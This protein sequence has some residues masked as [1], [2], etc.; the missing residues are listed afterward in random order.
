MTSALLIQ[1]ILLQSW[2]NEALCAPYRARNSQRL[3]TPFLF[4]CPLSRKTQTEC[5]RH[6]ARSQI[7]PKRPCRKLSPVGSLDLS[8]LCKQTKFFA[9][10]CSLVGS[11]YGGGRLVVGIYRTRWR[12]RALNCN[13]SLCIRAA[14]DH[15]HPGSTYNLVSDWKM[16]A[17]LCKQFSANI[18]DVH[19]TVQGWKSNSTI[20]YHHLHVPSAMQ[21][22]LPSCIS[23]PMQCVCLLNFASGRQLFLQQLPFIWSRQF[24][25]ALALADAAPRFAPNWRHRLLLG[26]R[27]LAQHCPLALRKL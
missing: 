11:D 5:W 19:K 9:V 12:A 4:L 1:Q 2:I 10:H 23:A 16:L 3:E 27:N 14:T 22:G 15:Y 26:H 25:G 13:R 18:S 21:W 6:E 24:C 17:M 8:S 20:F 7:G